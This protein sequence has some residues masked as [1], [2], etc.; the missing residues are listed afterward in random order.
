MGDDLS[1]LT[2]SKMICIISSY[3]IR[4]RFIRKTGF[5][6]PWLVYNNV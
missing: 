3:D 1:E 6:Y 4:E 5:V 2:M